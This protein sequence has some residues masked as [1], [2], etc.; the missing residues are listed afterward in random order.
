MLRSKGR[1]TRGSALLLVLILMLVA[2]AVSGAMLHLHWARNMTVNA[3]NQRIGRM[4]AAEAGLERAKLEVSKDSNWLASNVGRPAAVLGDGSTTFTVN[5]CAVSLTVAVADSTWY[6]VKSAAVREGARTVLGVTCHGGIPF[7]DYARFVSDGELL[8]GSYASYAGKVHCNKSIHCQGEYI[9]FYDDVTAVGNILYGGNAKKTTKFYKSATTGAPYVK[10]PEAEELKAIAETAP[11][12]ANVY[13]WADPNFRAQF[14]AAT[15]SLP[16]SDMKVDVTF[17]QDKMTV[18]TTSGGK[19]W[20]QTDIDVY[21]EGTLYSTVPV[22]VRGNISRR[23]S[24]VSPQD[25]YIDGALRYTDDSGD[26]QWQLVKNG[27]P[28]P[29]DH[30]Y[31]GWSTMGNW[32]GPEYDYIEA[33]DWADRKPV[34]DGE[35]INPALGIVTS[36]TIYLSNDNP[37]REIHAALFSS[38]DVIRRDGGS[39]P[40]NLFIHGAIITTGTNPVSSFFSYRTY[41]YDPHLRGNPPPGFPGSEGAAFHNWH[42][43]TLEGR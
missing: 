42:I 16:D 28:E 22:S 18:V 23:M 20:T 43:D 1:E 32:S 4:Y 38:G 15:G 21:H 14:Q 40:V 30:G 7:A 26:G 6:L 31:N 34:V 27:V 8:I 19:T 17:K 5:D 2:V 41:S 9:T 11:E 33:P 36:E 13:D 10:L 3:A 37:N 29:F 24:V 39:A 12:G 35:K 25:V